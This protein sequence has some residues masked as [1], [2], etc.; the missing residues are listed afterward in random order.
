MILSGHR[1]AC[2]FVCPIVY[3]DNVP[4][5]DGGIVDSIPLMHARKDGYTRNVVV[6]TRNR[7]GTVKIFRALRFL[8][9]FIRN[10]PHL[11]EA[12]NRRSHVYNEQLE[13]VERQEDAGNYRYTSA[14]ADSGRPY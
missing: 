4:M 2:L 8:H 12:I 13:L 9:S 6:L 14:E 5:L 7:G 3:V 11:R 10:T 1:A